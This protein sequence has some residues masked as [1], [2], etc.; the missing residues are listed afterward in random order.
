VP[1]R[2]CGK[3]AFDGFDIDLG[4]GEVRRRGV[5][6]KLQGQPFAVLA[7]LLERPGELVTREELKQRIWG[8]QTY[9]DFD[10][11]LNKA[12]KNIRAALGDSAE[13]PRYVETLPKR[14]YRFIARL[15]SS[16]EDHAGSNEGSTTSSNQTSDL[17]RR[18]QLDRITHWRSRMLPIAGGLAIAMLLIIA[19]TWLKSRRERE[20]N[21][22]QLTTN[23]GENFVRNS[24]VS[25]DGRYLLYGD[26]IG[27]HLR[28]IATGETHT[29]ER[30]KALSP[31]RFM[32]SDR[33]VPGPDLLHRGERKAHQRW[34]DSKQLDGERLGRRNNRTS[35][36]GDCA[37]DF[38]GRI[39]NRFYH[40][41]HQFR[42][43]NRDYGG[44][45]REPENCG[46]GQGFG[47]VQ[48][49]SMVT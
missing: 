43:R 37:I 4:T 15:N 17:L 16:D 22:K 34:P 27:I 13:E 31:G 5:K 11:A 44:A 36:Q 18:A 7:V 19:F 6:V 8:S 42:S 23:N 24:V 32:V 20:L 35:G 2:N 40:W 49:T 39:S 38:A 14:G 48:V 46:G 3:V 30:P 33:L 9:V 28:V 29:L 1:G 26:K 47:V 45:R 21:L 25:P 12:V 41:W 10:Q